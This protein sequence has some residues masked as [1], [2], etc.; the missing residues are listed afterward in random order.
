MPSCHKVEREIDDINFS[1]GIRC[2]HADKTTSVIIW[3]D[4]YHANDL[5]P[6][7]HW[8]HGIGDSKTDLQ[9]ETGH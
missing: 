5:R 6:S 4:L 8:A 3:A 2:R 1:S 7:C 9:R